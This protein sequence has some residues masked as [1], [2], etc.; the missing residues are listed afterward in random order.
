MLSRHNLP[1][2]KPIKNL[3]IM[4]DVSTGNGKKLKNIYKLVQATFSD[5][6]ISSKTAS[7][8]VQRAHQTP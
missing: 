7:E 3:E 2:P 1:T 5:R 8:S 4:T 6:S